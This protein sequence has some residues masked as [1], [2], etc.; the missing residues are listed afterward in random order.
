MKKLFFY[1]LSLFCLLTGRAYAGCNLFWVLD[2]IPEV[3]E[4]NID[5]TGEQQYFKK[6]FDIMVGGKYLLKDVKEDDIWL[7]GIPIPGNVRYWIQYNDDWVDVPGG[8]KYR[9]SS[10]LEIPNATQVPGYKT[11]VSPKQNHSWAWEGALCAK[12][13]SEYL[14]VAENIAGMSL[15]VDSSHAYPGIY[16]ISLPIRVAYE[17]NKGG[18]MIGDGWMNYPSILSQVPQ[19]RSSVNVKVN[20]ACT[21]SDKKLDVSFGNITDKDVLS[22]TEKV[23][24][25]P[26]NCTRQIIFK[27][28]LEGGDK[29]KNVTSCGQG[30]CTLTFDD[31]SDS[32]SAVRSSG[33]NET[34]IHV[35]LKSDKPFTGQFRGSAILKVIII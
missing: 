27:M 16:T 13:G 14:F 23:V 17:E 3:K 31:G 5:A 4:I 10:S 19:L 11:V 7:S 2:N 35:K 15:E 24:K 22:G 26:M 29:G 28:A 8:L 32:K 6:S 20:N 18:R 1:V 25:F 12:Q 21:F 9:I 33:Y 30:T 34:N